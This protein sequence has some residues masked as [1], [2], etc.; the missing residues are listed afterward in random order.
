MTCTATMPLAFTGS[1]A[2]VRLQPSSLFALESRSMSEIAASPSRRAVLTGSLAGLPVAAAL[3]A[4]AQAAAEALQLSLVFSLRIEIGAP[5]ELGIIDGGRKR[6]IPIL[7]GEIMGERLKGKVLRGGG[8]WQTILPGGLTEVYARYSLQAEDGTIIGIENKGVRV[9]SP[10]VTARIAK[11]EDVDPSL[12]YFRTNPCFQVA[13]GPHGWLRRHLFVG[14]GI[15][16]PDH[17]VLEV[18]QLS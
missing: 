9:A 17:V 15:R 18:F 12:Y 6:F 8:D 13:D 11:G 2:K 5:E 14:R 1:C 10:E 4:P 7:G 3:S 16:K